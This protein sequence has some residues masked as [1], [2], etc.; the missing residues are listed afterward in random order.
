MKPV[1]VIVFYRKKK[2]VGFGLRD[3]GD[4]PA[5]QRLLPFVYKAGNGDS[6][7]SHRDSSHQ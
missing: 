7:E 3:L 2:L 6:V 5:D 1:G 4:P